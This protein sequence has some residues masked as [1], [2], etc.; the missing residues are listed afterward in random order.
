MCPTTTFVILRH[1]FYYDFSVLQELVHRSIHC[2]YDI[3]SDKVTHVVSV[4]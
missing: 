3:L 2:L 1:L 4:S